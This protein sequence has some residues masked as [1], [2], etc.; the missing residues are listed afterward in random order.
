MVER[1]S[2]ASARRAGRSSS[3]SADR[4]RTLLFAA[5]SGQ[6]TGAVA[7][8]GLRFPG[9]AGQSAGK[10]QTSTGIHGDGVIHIGRR[11]A[12]ALAH[13]AA[14]HLCAFV[15]GR[16]V[17]S[18]RRLSF[19][20]PEGATLQNYGTVFAEPINVTGV[21][22][23]G[24]WLP[25]L[26][27]RSLFVSVMVTAATV[28]LAYPWPTISAFHV[29]PNRKSLWLFLIT[30]PFWTSYLIR[31]FL[32]KVILG[33]SGVVNSALMGLG[34][35]D[36]PLTFI[37]YNVNAVCHHAK[38]RLCPFAILPLF[39]ALEKIDR[40]LL[41]ASQDLGEN[42]L[43]NIPARHLAAFG[44]WHR[45]GGLDRVHPDDRRLRDPRTC[46]RARRAVDRQPHSGAVPAGE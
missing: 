26:L 42:R 25:G 17:G 37:L 34:L 19:S 38:P 46:G 8:F 41:E 9:D 20:G 33:Y 36:E 43:T 1:K 23:D 28:L 7:V 35:I 30:I 32:W 24:Q 4:R 6:N 31:I 3:R 5:A 11:A 21:V 22:R 14:L 27:P 44:S 39:V 45:G 16:A 15:D 40:S 29:S 18:G 13:A 12:C 2:T 10:E